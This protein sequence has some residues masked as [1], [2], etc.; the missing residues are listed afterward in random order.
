M[1]EGL[2]L[3][4]WCTWLGGA[5]AIGGARGSAETRASGAEEIANSFKIS[6]RLAPSQKLDPAELAGLLGMLQEIDNARVKL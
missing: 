1:W 4:S 5:F 3:R 6:R 2:L